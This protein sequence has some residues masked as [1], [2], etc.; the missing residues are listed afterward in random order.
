MASDE[1]NDTAFNR[2]CENVSIPTA[3]YLTSK[4]NRKV[5]VMTWI[6]IIIMAALTVYQ[7]Y[8]RSAYYGTEPITVVVTENNEDSGVMPAMVICPPGQFR[9]SL[10]QGRVYGQYGYDHRES[11]RSDLFNFEEHRDTFISQFRRKN[12][13][14]TSADVD[15]L[16]QELR[17]IYE[18]LKSVPDEELSKVLDRLDN[19]SASLQ[20]RFPV[21]ASLLLVSFFYL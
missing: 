11:V 16:L 14:F 18:D 17:G 8:E 6:L 12:I 7:V 21:L 15:A 1:Q 13:S 2:F 3:K 4:H 9:A 5:R 19:M 10:A 20:D